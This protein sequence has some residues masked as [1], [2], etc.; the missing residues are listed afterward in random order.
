[1]YKHILIPTD[2]SPTAAKAVEAGIDYARETAA[3]VTFFTALP[4]YPVP[5]VSEDAAMRAVE[6]PRHS[7]STGSQACAFADR[8]AASMIAFTT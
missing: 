8:Y 1:M 2:G 4:E 5:Y 7:S 6:P 3:R